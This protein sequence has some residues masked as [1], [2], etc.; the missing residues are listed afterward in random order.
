MYRKK[1]IM[2]V[3]LAGRGV[4]I[5]KKIEKELASV[6]IVNYNS[7]KL[8]LQTV[9]SIIKSSYPYIE[10]I[11]IDNN[12]E[13]NSV[14]LVI[15]YLKNTRFDI[16]NHY[17]SILF[18]LLNK[19]YGFSGGGYLG[20]MLARGNYVFISNPDII[21]D[22]KAIEMMI[23][24]AKKLGSNIIT[25]LVLLMD[26]DGIVN[27][28]G[29]DIHYAGFGLLRDVGKIYDSVNDDI[30][31]VMAPH[32]SFFVIPRHILNEIRGFDPTYTLF[33]ED[34]DIGWRAWIHGYPTIYIPYARIWHKWGYSTGK[35]SPNKLYL[36]ERNRIITLLSNYTLGELLYLAP[37]LLAVEAAILIYLLVNK[38]AGVKIQVYADIIRN[39]NYIVNRKKKLKRKIPS[40]MLTKYMKSTINHVYF[41]RNYLEALNKV[42]RLIAR[43]IL[44]E[45]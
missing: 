11:I 28:K 16:N 6:V 38:I 7:G 3:N 34:T 31:I 14:N 45:K 32:G 25:P 19:N 30:E 17:R 39:I 23:Y 36:L 2:I 37:I 42:L 5:S 22:Y 20:A 10:I 29:M 26:E 18:V 13:D 24:F 21:V 8:L 9:K 41:K 27:T 35:L 15:E 33:N 40:I 4:G 1:K 44:L 43:I 12:S